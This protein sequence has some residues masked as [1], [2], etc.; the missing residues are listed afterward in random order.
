MNLTAFAWTDSNLA[1]LGADRLGRDHLLSGGDAL[2]GRGRGEEG[3][4]TS[5]IPLHR[6]R[7]SAPD[8]APLFAS[9]LP[10]MHQS[11]RYR[12]SR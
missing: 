8:Q 6:L 11:S 9:A 1:Q 7:C 10:L 3:A 5:A 2:T 12:L 4:V